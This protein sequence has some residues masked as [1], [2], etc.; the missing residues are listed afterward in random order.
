MNDEHEVILAI[1]GIILLIVL[2]IVGPIITIYA[3][4]YL[5][6]LSIPV[7]F[8]TWLSTSWLCFAVGGTSHYSKK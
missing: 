6:S 1:L 8:W 3:I 2:A 5:F 4:N 7:N